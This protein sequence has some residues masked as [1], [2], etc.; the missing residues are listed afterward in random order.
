MAKHKSSGGLTPYKAYLFRTK[1][2]VIDE[3]RTIM[4]DV[5]GDE[6]G[7][8]L[9]DIHRN[10]GPTYSCVSGWFYGKTRRPQ[11]ASIEAAGRALGYKRSWVKMKN[12]DK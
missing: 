5:F 6:W 1:D 4:Q 3:L 9:G 8:K 12:G 7:K 2:P 10:G 11:S